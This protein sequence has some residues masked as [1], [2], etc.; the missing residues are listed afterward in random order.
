MKDTGKIALLTKIGIITIL[1]ASILVGCRKKEVPTSDAFD[2]PKP[3]TI[4]WGMKYG[5]SDHAALS[6]TNVET[7]AGETVSGD[8]NEKVILGTG[9]STERWD[10]ATDPIAQ[11]Y[12]AKFL[13]AD[14]EY[15]YK[16]ANDHV[17]SGQI[18]FI[19]ARDSKAYKEIFGFSKP[20][21]QELYAV[22]E[23]NNNISDQYKKFIHDFIH[24]YLTLYPDADFSV[25]K[26]NLQTLI[27]DEMTERQIQ[28]KA[29]SAGTV[30]CY[31]NSENT[32]CIANDNTVM[33]KSTD[34]YV[35]LTHEL[36]H[37]CR[38]CR[39][40]NIN[41]RDI[42]IKFYEDTDM[43]LYEDEALV[44]YFAYQLQG[45]GKKPI[46]YT[47]QSNIYRQILDGMDYDGSD[48]MNHSVNY[49]IEKLQEKFDKTGIH[50]PAYHFVNLVD[51]QAY[52]HYKNYVE[53]DYEDFE[54]LYKALADNYAALHLNSDMTYE[55]TEQEWNNFW[56]DIYFNVA[57]LSTPYPELNQECFRPYWEEYVRNLGI[58]KK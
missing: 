53:K 49:F 46:Y 52:N 19:Y 22:L 31:L 20:T 26:H 36:L 44:T 27:V 4:A 13:P 32:I 54:D 30:A 24:D 47:L 41:G 25:F 55:E 21:E 48:Y 34:D 43:G 51:S 12:L 17:A 15:D 38:I 33:D 56:D 42:A 58:S 35:I 45:L 39:S 14:D 37:A 40:K 57:E 18:G 50:I 2:N 7:T 10:E 8:Q 16:W 3:G 6:G 5:T 23:S 28:I 29:M 1:S 11:K 9:A